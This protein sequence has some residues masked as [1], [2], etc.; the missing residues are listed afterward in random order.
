MFRKFAVVM[1]ALG[2]MLG[3]TGCNMITEVATNQLYAP[4]DGAQTSVG[5]VQARN[6]LVLTDGSASY[7]IGSLVN[8]GIDAASATVKVVS[9]AAAQA[10]NIVLGADSK[11]DLGFNFAQLGAL[12]PIKLSTNPAAGST[13]KVAVDAAGQTAEMNVPVLDLTLPEY[14][15][16]FEAITAFLN[17]G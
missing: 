10:S 11:L 14:K 2:L 6:F 4:S 7:L 5:E 13:V 9:D 15:A 3:A 1:A 12:S 17:L 16:A 8:S